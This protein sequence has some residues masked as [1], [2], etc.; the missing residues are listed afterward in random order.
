MMTYIQTKWEALKLTLTAN[1]CEGTEG[2]QRLRA[3]GEGCWC[4]RP[5]KRTAQSK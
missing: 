3:I 1:Y 2:Q 4:S 5:P